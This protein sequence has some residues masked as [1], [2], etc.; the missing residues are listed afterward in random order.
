MHPNRWNWIKAPQKLAS[1]RGAPAN[2]AIQ[3]FLRRFDGLCLSLQKPRGRSPWKA[4][5]SKAG[6]RVMM[7]RRTMASPS[8]TGWRMIWPTPGMAHSGKLVMGV[9]A[10]IPDVPRLL[11]V[12]GLPRSSSG[13]RLFVRARSVG[14]RK[15]LAIYCRNN[16]AISRGTGTG[17]SFSVSS[18]ILGGMPGGNLLSRVASWAGPGPGREGRK[19]AE[20]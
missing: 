6:L 4:P 16:F 17:R 8:A 5:W 18:A 14:W 11:M 10:S 3:R 15:R 2:S 1:G 13:A 19:K 12:K 7:S 9:K 20:I